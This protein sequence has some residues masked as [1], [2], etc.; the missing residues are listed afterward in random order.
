MTTR[1]GTKLSFYVHPPQDVANAAPAGVAA[2]DVPGRPDP[3][4]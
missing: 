4:A 1:D 3:H 2:P